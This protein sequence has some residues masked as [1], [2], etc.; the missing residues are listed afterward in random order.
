VSSPATVRPH[1]GT[2]F[3]LTQAV[4]AMRMLRERRIVGKAVIEI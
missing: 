3:P 2:H 1:I 4:D